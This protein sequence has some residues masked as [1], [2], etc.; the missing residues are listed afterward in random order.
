[1]FTRKLAS[2][3][4]VLALGLGAGTASAVGPN[5]GK[6]IDPGEIAAWDISI[7]PDGTGLP[8][9]SGTAAQGAPIYAQKGLM[10]HGANGQGGSAGAGGGGGPPR[11]P[12]SGDATG[13]L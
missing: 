8:P 1:M 5:L 6:P 7:L 2:F 12:G 13:H 10:G 9:G 11:R 4:V 3:A